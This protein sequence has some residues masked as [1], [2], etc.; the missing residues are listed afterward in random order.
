MASTICVIVSVYPD[1]CRCRCKLC[2]REKKQQN[3]DDKLQPMYKV[4]AGR[5]KEKTRAVKVKEGASR[6]QSR[7]SQTQKI[8]LRSYNFVSPSF[9]YFC[10]F[11]Y[12]LTAFTSPNL[13]T[14]MAPV[15]VAHQQ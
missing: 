7:N 12:F 9:R 10:S 15:S 11:L 4:I 8:K 5:Q 14:L 2:E 13:H 6:Q 3:G 1:R